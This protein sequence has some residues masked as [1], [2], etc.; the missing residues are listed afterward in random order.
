[1][2]RLAPRRDANE[3]AVVNAL[4][5]AGALVWRINEPGVPDLLVGFGQRWVLLEVKLPLGP[6]GGS[7][8]SDLNPLQQEFFALAK[9]SALPVAVVRDEFE[10]LSFVTGRN[11][12]P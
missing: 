4:T 7:A 11:I 1:M 5:R 8:H 2:K 12:R 3:Q 10:A 9:S 6:Q